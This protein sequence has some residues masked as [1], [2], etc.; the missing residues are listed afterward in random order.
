M[1]AGGGM[2]NKDVDNAADND[3]AKM[4]AQLLQNTVEMYTTPEMYPVWKT[5]RPVVVIDEGGGN[6]TD[7]RVAMAKSLE[8][9]GGDGT[10]AAEGGSEGV[11]GDIL[12]NSAGGPLLHR[13][14]YLA[15]TPGA[16][17]NWGLCSQKEFTVDD[18]SAS[19]GK[20]TH[21][22]SHTTPPGSD[23]DDEHNGMAPLKGGLSASSSS[24]PSP[25]EDG[26]HYGSSHDEDEE[27]A[28]EEEDDE[29]FPPVLYEDPV[30]PIMTDDSCDNTEASSEDIKKGHR[31]H[32]R[33]P[34]L[35]DAMGNPVVLT[36]SP[37][38]KE[39][40]ESMT[41]LLG[42]GASSASFASLTISGN[43]YKKSPIMTW[44]KVSALP[45]R[46][47]T[48]EA[49]DVTPTMD[50]AAAKVDDMEE[51]E[52][53]EIIDHWN[54]PHDSTFANYWETRKAEK[55][56][57]KRDQAASTL[58]GATVATQT[59]EAIPEL[60]EHDDP[61]DTEE[62]L[63]IVCY[64]LPVILSR[65]P[66]MGEW[67][68]CWSE[69]LIAKSELH[70]V[71]ST[72]KSTWIGTISSIPQQI[73]ADPKEQE[74]IR[75][76]LKE[77]DCIP[78]FFTESHIPENLLDLMYLGF[79]KQVLWPSYHNVDLLDL[80]TNGW[81]QRQRN[82]LRV[83]PVLACEKAEAEA[84]ERK[85]RSESV[86]DDQGVLGMGAAPTASSGEKV[87]QSDWDQRRLDSWW[88]AYIEVNRKFS[89]VVA[90][91]IT[92]GDVVWV[93]DYHLALFPRMLREIR[94]ETEVVGAGKGKK[95]VP[96]APSDTV[97]AQQKPVRMVFFIHVPFPT[98]QVFRELEHGEALLEG[99]LHADVV[100]FHAFDHARHFLNAA[101][102]I[103]GLTYESLVGGLI[104]VRHRG[105]KVL[106]TVSNVSV[107]GDIIDALMQFPSVV[108]EAAALQSKH[109]GRSIIS[110]IAVAQRLSGV[111]YKLLAFE[112]LLTD[113]PVWQSKVV[114]LQRC[115]IPGAR[116]V[117]EADTLREV[118][119]LVKRIQSKFGHEVIDYEEQVGSVYPIDQ[120]LAIWTSSQVMMHTPIREGLNLCPLEFVF[121]RKE[122]A[123]P[124]VVI[125]SEFSAVSSILNGALRVNPYDIQ[126]CVT[127][128]DAA[129]SMT[130][131]ERDARRARDID[132]VSTSPS[133]LW[134]RNVLRDLNDATL[135][136]LGS[137]K[138]DAVGD[139]SPDSILAR[140]AELGLEHLDLPALEQAYANTKTRVIIIDF[141]GTLVVKEPAGKYLKREILGTS[142]F[143]PSHMTMLALQRMCSDP[144]NTI[145]VVSGDSQQNLEMAVGNVPGLGLAASNGTCFAD[146]AGQ[147]GRSW[148]YL[149]FGVDWNAVKKV[150]S[151]LIIFEKRRTRFIRLLFAWKAQLFYVSCTAGCYADHIKIHRKNKWFLC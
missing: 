69:S 52:D 113:Y 47:R 93:H 144:K 119:S 96:G 1:G 72:R 145:Y 82:T 55:E 46:T 60:D 18:G 142:C 134:T 149:D 12:L 104:G 88:N 132:F 102:R 125:S 84:M 28:G 110:G 62:R 21:A 100:G 26:L 103:L 126:M 141:N 150:S 49:S 91:L 51:G 99:M 81:G 83:D 138:M 95:P 30:S 19:T 130:H 41:S 42:A 147:Q 34:S 56:Q 143:K 39:A 2:A 106:V 61:T 86:G 74:A 8:S 109:S 40:E 124:G 118:R 5:R 115:L 89:Q 9:S 122:P 85:I 112:R 38:N 71:S 121:A 68:A 7:S 25:M 97:A 117:D 148:Q 128:I 140:E 105:T 24:S 59:A 111:S 94:N 123:D 80:A 45:Y 43:Q 92:G 64:H 4:H 16:T 120:R 127:S 13:Y 6:G 11:G 32:H 58:K 17:I 31:G 54:K 37:T 98:S 137:T 53:V 57:K 151:Y 108:D 14:R 101:K 3:P 76:V 79:C 63:Y 139:S 136:S 75:Q 44:E 23:D 77:M 87:L 10:T 65:D 67:T 15:V 129:L 135:G 36:G 27:G 48:I 90:D 22:T 146:P 35:Y 33:V 133:G 114:L 50:V 116:R 107:E 66:S 78:I 20:N 131:D 73:L 70:G 29:E